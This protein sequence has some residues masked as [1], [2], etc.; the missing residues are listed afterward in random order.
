LFISLTATAL[1]A[2]LET[3]QLAEQGTNLKYIEKQ[4]GKIIYR[5]FYSAISGTHQKGWKY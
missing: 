2:L 1:P 4:R 3:L 5:I